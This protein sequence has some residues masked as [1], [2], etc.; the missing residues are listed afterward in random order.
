[1]INIFFLLLLPLSCLGQSNPIL[2]NYTAIFCFGDSFADAGNLGL[3]AS[4]ISQVEWILFPPYAEAFGLPFVE[5]YWRYDGT[6]IHGANFAVAGA[7]ILDYEFY[8]E[9]NLNNTL[10]LNTSLNVQLDWF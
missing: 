3:I 2:Q 1:M 6:L 8:I 7:T 5:P 10:M 9:N 4:L